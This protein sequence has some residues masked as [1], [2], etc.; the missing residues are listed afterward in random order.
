ME[1]CSLVQS[2]SV[3]NINFSYKIALSKAYIKKIEWEVHHG[4]I[5]KNRNYTLP[6]L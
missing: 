5:T 4:P 6:T 2:T 3:E 1:Y